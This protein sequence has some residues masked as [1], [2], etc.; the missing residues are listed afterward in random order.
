M[1]YDK[2]YTKT[3]TKLIRILTSFSFLIIF[4]QLIELIL[5]KHSIEQFSYIHTHRILFTITNSLIL[6][7]CS[8]I[9]FYPLN[10]Y[11]LSITLFFHSTLILILNPSNPIGTLL[12][13]MGVLTIDQKSKNKYP[14]KY[15]FLIL[16]FLFLLFTNIRCGLKFFINIFISNFVFLFVIL[17]FNFFFELRILSI[18]K[19][20]KKILNLFEYKSFGITKRDSEWLQLIQKNIKYETIAINYELSI[21]TVKNRLK[22]IY[23]ILNLKD[24][25]D[26][27]NKY[28]DH[29]I[30]YQDYFTNLVNKKNKLIFITK[31]SFIP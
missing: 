19:S 10:R 8:F 26:F 15:I 27:L 9:L 21:G 25:S 7:L 1:I 23:D 17:A 31:F 22:I 28:K 4:L 18:L 24:K 13:L 30:E 11:L 5:N 2:K 6:I 12:Y 14:S 16:C 20:K 29:I 3:I